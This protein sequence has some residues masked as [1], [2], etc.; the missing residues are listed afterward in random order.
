MVKPGPV[1]ARV[2]GD[3]LLPEVEFNQRFTGVQVQ[4]L[5]HVLV[6]HRVIMAPVL[7]MVINVD[8]DRFDGDVAVGVPGPRVLM[9][10]YQAP[11][12]QTGGCRAIA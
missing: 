10:V 2:R 8:R 4:L 11:R 1:L 3:P 12:R 9:P 6:R 5:A 7:D